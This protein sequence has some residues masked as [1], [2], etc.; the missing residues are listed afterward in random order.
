MFLAGDIGGTKTVL[1]LFEETASGLRQERDQTFH[2]REHPTFDE[3]LKEF[4][5]GSPRVSLQASCFGVAGPIIDGRVRTTNLPWQL[6]EQVLSRLL[7]GSRVKLYN[8]LEAMAYG[9][10]HLRPEE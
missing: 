5:Q 2:S 8:D 3:I 1:A 7:S 9:M 10:L 6:D 4:L